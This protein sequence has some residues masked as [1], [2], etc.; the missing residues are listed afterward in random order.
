METI[1]LLTLFII[2]VSASLDDTTTLTSVTDTVNR[3][4]SR[5]KME[6]TRLEITLKM[7]E[8]D[9]EIVDNDYGK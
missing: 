4:T 1:V 6:E 7:D 2:S 8:S 3:V 9:K 5:S